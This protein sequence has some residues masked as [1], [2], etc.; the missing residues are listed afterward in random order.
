MGES[1]KQGRR[2]GKGAETGTADTAQISF[3]VLGR[4]EESGCSGHTLQPQAFLLESSVYTMAE[5]SNQGG[6]DIQGCDSCVLAAAIARQ[7]SQ[8][9]W[10][11]PPA[12]PELAA[13]PRGNCSSMLGYSIASLQLQELSKQ[14]LNG[15]D[16]LWLVSVTG[17]EICK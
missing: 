6:D 14:L 7:I 4:E 3:Q 9:A 10:Q 12:L 17:V 1:G 16:T 8:G 15:R 13:G 2:K 11:P 5:P